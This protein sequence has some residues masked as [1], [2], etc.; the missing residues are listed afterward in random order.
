MQVLLEESQ[1]L[2]SLITLNAEIEYADYKSD[3][4]SNEFK[5]QLELYKAKAKFLN[6]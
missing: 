5:K 2:A 6:S 4:Q 3:K 1:Q